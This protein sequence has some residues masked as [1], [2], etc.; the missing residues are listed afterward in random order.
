MKCI[1]CAR[2]TT[3]NHVFCDECLK[4][5]EL[6]PVRSDTPVVLPDRT[7]HTPVK[8]KV[9]RLAASKWEDQITR[10]KSTIFWLILIIILLSVALA[11]CMC[12]LLDIAPDWLNEFI[13]YTPLGSAIG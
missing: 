3:E 1:R 9:F 8:P 6:Y 7:D 4:E 13:G 5:M 11:V 2:D 10:L 12:I